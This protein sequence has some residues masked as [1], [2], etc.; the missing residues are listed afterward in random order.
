M[1]HDIHQ[2]RILI[3]DFGSQYTQLI[4]R[5]IRAF[6]PAPGCYSFLEGQRLKVWAAQPTAHSA[7]GLPGDIVASNDR[8][9]SVCC[10]SGAIL[11]ETL[12]VAGSR[13]IVLKQA[14]GVDHPFQRARRSSLQAASTVVPIFACSAPAAHSGRVLPSSHCA[15]LAL[16]SKEDNEQA[17]PQQ[18]FVE[19]Q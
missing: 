2:H 16:M 17:Q 18:P 13:A 7:G 5:R 3:L 4:A 19:L 8:G 11:L 12:Q 15:K 10:G 14:V 6:N 9:I 1:T